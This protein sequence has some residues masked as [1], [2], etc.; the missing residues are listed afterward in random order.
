MIA[1]DMKY[2]ALY[3]ALRFH[4]TA[5]DVHVKSYNGYRV[6]IYAEKH[7]VDFG[8]KI[9]NGR[10]YDLNSHKSFVVLECIDRLLTKGYSPEKIMIASD[11]FDIRLNVRDSTVGI[12]C[13]AWED[14]SGGIE[15][16]FADFEVSYTSRLV[17]GLLEYKGRYYSDGFDFDFGVGSDGYRSVIKPS[18]DFEIIG[19]ELV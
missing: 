8:E 1:K 12:N 3:W 10:K 14:Y 19:S 7:S 15:L 11:F 13:F 18:S 6:T 16:G 4:E 5:E 9:Q 2:T 17:S